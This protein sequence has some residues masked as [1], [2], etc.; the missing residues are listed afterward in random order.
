MLILFK[1]FQLANYD[2]VRTAFN[3]ETRKY[4]FNISTFVIYNL[5]F[6]LGLFS[7]YFMFNYIFDSQSTPCFGGDQT[8]WYSSTTALFTNRSTVPLRITQLYQYILPL[9]ASGLVLTIL[10]FVQIMLHDK[11]KYSKL[12]NPIVLIAPFL[13][14]LTLMMRVGIYTPFTP[15]WTS[16]SIWINQ[17]RKANYITVFGMFPELLLLI[18]LV[19]SLLI[20]WIFWRC[21]DR[22]VK[23]MINDESMSE[24]RPEEVAV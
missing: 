7:H 1:V 16:Y 15:S 18:E 23:T 3:Y 17:I 8:Q 14:A 24:I 20:D 2:L 6:C 9:I 21:L 4:N 12:V 11:I 19:L 13:L 10:A 5:V 22:N